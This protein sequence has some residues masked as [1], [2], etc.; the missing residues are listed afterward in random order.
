MTISFIYFEWAFVKLKF[1]VSEEYTMY[2]YIYF[3][4]KTYIQLNCNLDSVH[5]KLQVFNAPVG[6][7][8]KAISALKAISGK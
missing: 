6:M 5:F 7:K 8:T 3:I 1:I 2:A 4:F